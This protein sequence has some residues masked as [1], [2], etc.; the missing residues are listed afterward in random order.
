MKWNGT[1]LRLRFFNE[2]DAQEIDIVISEDL[3]DL[4][5]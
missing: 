5:R 3:L 2:T 4:T 1:S